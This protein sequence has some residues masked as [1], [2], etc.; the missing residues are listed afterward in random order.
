MVVTL[1]ATVFSLTNQTMIIEL[2]L[3]NGNTV[4]VNVDNIKYFVEFDKNNDGK[5]GAELVISC[6]S[7]T[8]SRIHV[9]EHP[10][11]I[12]AQIDGV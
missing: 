10:M 9:K 3:F 11:W 7:E 4:W 12:A 1:V 5:P 2:T 8:G 6:N